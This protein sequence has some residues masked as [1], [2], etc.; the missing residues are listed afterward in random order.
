[1]VLECTLELLTLAVCCLQ[2]LVDDVTLTG[3]DEWKRSDS[4]N[5]HSRVNVSGLVAGETYQLR[6]V[7]LGR[8]GNRDDV[9]SQPQTVRVGIA[10]GESRAVIGLGYSLPQGE[11]V[12]C[13]HHDWL[14]VT[15]GRMSHLQSS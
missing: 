2:L 14:L 12:T 9:T 10:Q 13:G 1:M 7:A 6:V 8:I 3:S 5:E 11:C 15:T 4:E